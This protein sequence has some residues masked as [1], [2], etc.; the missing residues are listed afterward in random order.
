MKNAHMLKTL[1]HLILH[2]V[3]LEVKD[4]HDLL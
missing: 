2:Q 1:E 4:K 3:R